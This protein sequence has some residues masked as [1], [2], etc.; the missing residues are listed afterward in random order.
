MVTNLC[1]VS[2]ESEKLSK[3]LQFCTGCAEVPVMGFYSPSQITVSTIR[4]VYPNASTCP[5]ILELPRQCVSEQQFGDN[6]DAVVDMQSTGF[7]VV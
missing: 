6:L 7:G 4:S 3:L 5:M 1:F 2:L